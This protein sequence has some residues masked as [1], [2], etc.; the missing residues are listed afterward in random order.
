MSA[1]NMPAEALGHQNLY[2]DND[3]NRS[4]LFLDQISPTKKNGGKSKEVTSSSLASKVQSAQE[5]TRSAS[6]AN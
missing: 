6:L 1:L 5:A 3:I 4:G 2:T